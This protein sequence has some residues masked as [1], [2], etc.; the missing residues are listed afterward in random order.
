MKTGRLDVDELIEMFREVLEDFKAELIGELKNADDHA[1]KV[2]DDDP[3][4]STSE[5][6]KRWGK[7]R[8]TL[9]RLV[10]AKRLVPSGKYKRQFL[11]PTSD[12]IEL[13]GQ[14]MGNDSSL[15]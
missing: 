10:K 13:F 5:I 4:V 3:P 1:L 6:C 8:T 14:P 15:F 12:I 9:S 7:S 2:N 11:F